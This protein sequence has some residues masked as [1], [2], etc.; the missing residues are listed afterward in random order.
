MGW[1]ITTAALAAAAVAFSKLPRVE[2][3]T[4]ACDELRLAKEPQNYQCD[5]AGQH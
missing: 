2:K 3:V 5:E 1:V 4:P